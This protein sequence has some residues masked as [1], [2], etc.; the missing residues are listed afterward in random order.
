MGFLSD[1]Y[2]IKGDFQLFVYSSKIFCGIN[3]RLICKTGSP[4]NGGLPVKIKMILFGR[5][6]YT[7]TNGIAIE[8]CSI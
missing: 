8:L 2:R 4:N 7:C 3:C 6:N 5:D 1:R